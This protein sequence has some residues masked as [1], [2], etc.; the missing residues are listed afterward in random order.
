M[1]QTLRQREPGAI[2]SDWTAVLVLWGSC[3]SRS[4]SCCCI[5]ALAALQLIVSFFL[6]T[7]LDLSV[8]EEAFRD[9]AR[10]HLTYRDAE[11]HHGCVSF[12]QEA[13]HHLDH[14]L[15]QCPPCWTDP[16]AS[17]RNL[18][19]GGCSSACPISSPTLSFSLD[20]LHEHHGVLKETWGGPT[21]NPNHNDKHTA[22]FTHNMS[23]CRVLTLPVF[24]LQVRGALW[25]YNWACSCCVIVIVETDGW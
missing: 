4:G 25:S 1:E 12:S 3:V 15:G 13:I 5:T 20:V 23:P 6:S 21:R 17:A 11:T 24:F 7:L 18:P 16:R 19:G 10:C 2:A 8:L 9:K 14:R 22:V